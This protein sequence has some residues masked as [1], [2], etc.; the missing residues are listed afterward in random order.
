MKDAY[1][2]IGLMSG[3]S[4]DGLD[5]AECKF[6]FD[7][8]WHFEIIDAV[9]IAYDEH[10]QDRLKNCHLMS[11][12]ELAQTNV[13]LGKLHGN[14]VNSYIR[15]RRIKPD[16]ISSHGHTVFHQPENSLTLQ[17]ASPPHIAA[18]TGKTV[19][20]DFRT[21]DVAL[22]GQGAPLVPIGDLLLFP[23]YEFCLNLG[24]IANV[25]IKEKNGNAIQAFDICPC[26]MP[27]NFITRQLGFEYDDGGEFAAQG[28]IIPQMLNELNKLS[29]Y[30]SSPPKSLGREFFD[31]SFMPV[32]EDY[33]RKHIDVLA[34]LCEHI[35]Q[36]IASSLP[37]D[38]HKKMLVTGGGAFNKHLISL[39]RSK[40]QTEI[41]VPDNLLIQFKEALI[42]AF[43]GVLR[44]REQ[45]N[46]LRSVTGTAYDHV[47][48]AIYYHRVNP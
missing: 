44:V 45:N 10:W 2:V 14:L 34:T 3:T 41:I 18:S 12:L 20:A 6:H 30:K 48:G 19:V 25:S 11:G 29:Y 32:L 8:K 27:L 42:F 33:Q 4:L 35:A 28:K 21:L 39:L 36:Q 17:I 37:D 46:C 26:N 23:D 43:L 38:P 24:G 7:G 22:S 16:F 5:I 1:H 13:D 47:G 15:N 40:M 31:A 9:T